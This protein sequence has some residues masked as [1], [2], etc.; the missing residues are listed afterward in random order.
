MGVWYWKL[1]DKAEEEGQCMVVCE[2]RSSYTRHG[3]WAGATNCPPSRVAGSLTGVLGRV[4]GAGTTANRV[5]TTA[6]A[7]AVTP[8][9]CRLASVVG[10]STVGPT[11]ICF[12]FPWVAPR[13]WLVSR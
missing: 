3:P 4:Q 12:A 8:P 1:A 9:F 10:S 11:F 2:V 5:S 6:D 7:M 13:L